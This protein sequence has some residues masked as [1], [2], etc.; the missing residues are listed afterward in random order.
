MA[1]FAPH[2]WGI[3]YIGVLGIIGWLIFSLQGLTDDS[4]KVT[5]LNVGQG[6]AILIQTPEHKNILIDAGPS[7]SLIYELDKHLGFFNRKIDL[8]VLSHPHR[9]HFMGM[10]DAV[11]KYPFEA[12]M[13]TGVASQDPLYIDWV[14]SLKAQEVQ[15]LFPHHQQDWQIGKD[16]VLDVIYPFSGQGLIGQE[17]HNKNNASITIILRKLDGTPLML[18]SGDAEEEQEREIL[19]T[20]QE[21]EVDV[22]KLGHHGSRT[23]S[24]PR[25]LRAVQPEI[26]I[27]SAGIDNQFKHPHPETLEKMKD[28]GVEL[29]RTDLNGGVQ[30]TFN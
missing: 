18:F 17:M 4:T 3:L 13:I 12:I 10:L 28:F 15:I 11:E 26:A 30:I 21:T 19:M 14:Q 22:M 20:G 5:V 29:Y 8:F 2:Q 16:L 9:D 6:D 7:G 27:V 1:K 24:T 23:S 25:F